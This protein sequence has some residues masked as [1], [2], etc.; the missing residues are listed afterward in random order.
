MTP[1]FSRFR[2]GAL[3]GAWLFFVVAGPLMLAWT[4]AHPPGGPSDLYALGGRLPWSDGFDYWGA[5][6]HLMQQGV[7][8]EWGSRRPLNGAFLAARLVLLQDHLLGALLF[9]SIIIA[10]TLAGAVCV[11]MQRL[12]I[13]A[14][15]IFGLFMIVPVAVAQPTTQSEGLGVALGLAAVAALLVAA[16]RRVGPVATGV[17]MLFLALGMMVRP[18]AM[19]MLPAV[20]VGA[21]VAAWWPG[22]RRR[23][24]PSSR[25]WRAVL[26]AVI[27]VVGVGAAIGINAA[28]R[29][30]VADPAARANANFAGTL[31]GIARGT[32]YY[33]ASAWLR[34]EV[35]E[36]GGEAERAALAYRE[37][38][39]L[40]RS[41][42][43]TA[44]GTLTRHGVAFLK[45]AWPLLLLG[46]IGVLRAPRWE[47]W[48]WISGW[49]G[50]LASAPIIYGDG[51]VR[52]LAVSWPFMVLS[53]ASALRSRGAST[54][55]IARGTLAGA[56]EEQ[57]AETDDATPEASPV[58]D[59]NWRIEVLGAVAA[60]APILAAA[61]W[62]VVGIGVIRGGGQMPSLPMRGT[63]EV[64]QFPHQG[65]EEVDWIRNER[66]LHMVLVATEGE[67]SSVDQRFLDLVRLEPTEIPSRRALIEFGEP[68]ERV[69]TP[70]LLCVVYDIAQS[71][72][73][74]FTLPPDRTTADAIDSGAAVLRV[75]SVRLRDG[76]RVRVGRIVAPVP[77]DRLPQPAPRP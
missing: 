71:R 40:I 76:G 21:C 10:F 72:A 65:A 31:L 27:A 38:W 13:V 50:I 26:I 45:R 51:G 69:Q 36:S 9:Q 73:R 75:D 61:I 19:F 37:S 6:Q 35:G 41:Q 30:K 20:A 66:A 39:R 8:D 32:D 29:A 70:Y 2:A 5:A 34:G 60:G 42:P 68:L 47:R 15:A 22:A 62:T 24:A 18:G 54:S 23:V 14:G 55:G 67:L 44:V 59:L 43:W 4:W 28:V 49:L 58:T 63:F 33:E 7:L 48:F 56:L 74:V 17:G 46:L 57:A 77:A 64:D 16:H 11:A 3:I 53:A 52:C 12:G 25:R 1:R